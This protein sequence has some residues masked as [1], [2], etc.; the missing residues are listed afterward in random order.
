MM[1]LVYFFDVT[2]FCLLFLECSQLSEK[3]KDNVYNLPWQCMD[4]KNQKTLL[5]FLNR[6]Q[7][8]MHITCMGVLPVGV[9]SMASILKTCYSYFTILQSMDI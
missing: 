7:T 2:G 6:I 5:I 1:G 8:T 4:L 9:Q 3:L